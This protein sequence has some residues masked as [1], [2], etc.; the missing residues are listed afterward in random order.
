MSSYYPWTKY[1]T[2][3]AD[4]DSCSFKVQGGITIS[5]IQNGREDGKIFLKSGEK[6]PFPFK[7]TVHLNHLR[8]R[9]NRRDILNLMVK[10]ML[11]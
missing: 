7:L 4:K 2:S 10:S 11:F 3:N 1:Q 6:S 5:L 8:R 9:S